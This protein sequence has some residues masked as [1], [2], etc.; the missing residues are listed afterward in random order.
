MHEFDIHTRCKPISHYLRYT[1]KYYCLHYLH[2]ISSNLV[3]LLCVLHIIITGHYYQYTT[4]K[5]YTGV[6]NND[7]YNLVAILFLACITFACSQ[8]NISHICFIQIST[9]LFLILL[10]IVTTNINSTKESNKFI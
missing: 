1:D 8:T 9:I 6:H 5:L 10:E 7:V 4:C 3:Q 2:T